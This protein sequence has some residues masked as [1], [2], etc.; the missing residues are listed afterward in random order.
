MS[1]PSRLILRMWWIIQKHTL[2][3]SSSATELAHGWIILVFTYTR[4]HRGVLSGN[5]HLNVSHLA[6]WCIHQER[7][8]NIGLQNKVIHHLFLTEAESYLLAKSTTSQRR[9]TSR[10]SRGQN[11]ARGG[12]LI[13]FITRGRLVTRSTKMATRATTSSAAS[14]SQRR[15]VASSFLFFSI[16]FSSFRTRSL[17]EALAVRV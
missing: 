8:K 7:G 1:I 6:S 15:N 17:E 16:H 5:Q 14:L 9:D 3:T 10:V 13:S 2:I 11:E 12:R 4:T